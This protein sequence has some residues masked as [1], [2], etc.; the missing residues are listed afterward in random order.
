MAK[1]LVDLQTRAVRRRLLFN[2]GRFYGAFRFY[3]PRLQDDFEHI[4]DF[5]NNLFHE[6]VNLNP[7]M[8]EKIELMVTG[9]Q[10]DLEDALTAEVMPA[11]KPPEDPRW[12]RAAEAAVL[13]KVKAWHVSKWLKKGK[14]RSK[15]DPANPDITLVSY[16]DVLE[17][18][19]SLRPR[20]RLNEREKLEA[21]PPSDQGRLRLLRRIIEAKP[22]GKR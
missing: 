1:R 10:A 11:V 8:E 15:P 6:L 18:A 13:A 22:K 9:I 19:A 4:A 21:D 7:A 20:Q 16:A 5:T 12:M 3:G 14:V 17:R 2:A